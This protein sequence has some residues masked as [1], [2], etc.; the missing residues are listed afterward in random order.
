MALIDI[1][2]EGGSVAFSSTIRWTEAICG[3]SFGYLRFL[4]PYSFGSGRSSI[5]RTVFGL[6]PVSRATCR[7]ETPSWRIRRRM[8]D[9]CATSRYMVGHPFCEARR[10]RTAIY[11]VLG[12]AG[13]L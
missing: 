5:F 8:L 11:E 13:V 10:I 12:G 1:R 9:H 2:A 6:I 4:G 7:I 3:P